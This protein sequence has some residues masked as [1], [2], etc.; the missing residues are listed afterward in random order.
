MKILLCV[1]KTPDT[2]T[3]I[4]FTADKK[5]L[6]TAG[7]QFILN[8]SD[9]HSLAG[10]MELKEKYNAQVTVIH[11]GDNSS[12]PI[13]RKCLAVGADDAIL[14]NGNASDAYY[15]ASQIAAAV[16]NDPYDLVLCGRESIDFNGNSVCDML[17]EEMGIPSV[18]FVSSMEINGTTANLKRFIDGGEEKLTLNMPFAISATKELAEPRIPNMRG[19]MQSR[20]KTI[21][22]IEA[23]AINPLTELV[24]FEPPVKK[25]S[26]VMIDAAEAGKLIEILHEKEKVI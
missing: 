22:T 21:K 16:K 14:I 24:S 4:N 9:D 7:V 15:V 25:S 26:V 19:I 23:A 10:A 2:T 17:A 3:K 13:L 18:D 20:T 11:V 1:S 6:D 12:E 5:S 8:P